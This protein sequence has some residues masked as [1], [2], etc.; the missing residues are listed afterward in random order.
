MNMR[1]KKSV[2]VLAFLGIVAS[3]SMAQ[4]AEYYVDQATGNDG[5]GGT[6]SQPWKTISKANSTLRAGDT[7]YIK[8]GT[9]SNYISPASSGTSDANRITYRT[10]SSDVVTISNASY[11]ILLNGNDYV[12][13]IGDFVFSNLDRFMVLQNGANHNIIDGASFGPMRSLGDWAGSRIYQNSTY[14]V[15]RNA[16]FTRYGACS[17]GSDDGTLLDIGNENTSSDQTHHNL[18]ENSVFSY[19]GHHLLG[20][21]GTYNVI[22]NNYFHNEAWTNGKGN[23]NMY[24]AGYTASAGHNLFDGNRYG[25]S[26]VP[27]DAAGVSGVLIATSDNIFRRNMVYYNNL[28]GLALGSYDTA[29]SSRNKIYSNTFFANGSSDTAYSNEY[30][31]AVQFNDW[32]SS[33]TVSNAM[34]NNIYYKHK[35][36]YGENGSALSSQTVANNWDGDSQGNPMFVNASVTAPA[37]KSDSSLPD[38][39]LQSGSPAIDAGGPLTTISSAS[40]SGATIVVADAGYFTDGWGIIEGDLIQLEGSSQQVRITGVNYGTKTITL[41]TSISWTKGQG[42]MLAYNGSNPDAGALESG[43]SS[44]SQAPAAPSNL[45]ILSSE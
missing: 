7:V 25:Y 26:A 9:Y 31:C 27:C 34:K 42:V 40:G 35:K 43:S 3:S 32:T 41:S 16:V 14:N 6:A 29:D 8:R 20:V 17:G 13:V 36:T 24:N 37:N 45:R 10:F 39:R 19:G 38:F 44:G 18:I 23:R 12:S 1:A 11:G 22:R 28:C 33:S 30:H 2:I 5:N 4:A 15:V 21:N